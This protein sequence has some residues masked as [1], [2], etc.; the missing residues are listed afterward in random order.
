[1]S[2]LVIPRRMLGLI[3]KEMGGDS[4]PTGGGGS[5]LTITN[6]VDGY[7]LK[8]TGEANRVEGV[9]AIQYSTSGGPQLQISASTYISGA[10]N[11]LYMQG[12]NA[13]GDPARYQVHVSG[14]L[15]YVQE[16]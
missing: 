4:D 16:I 10:A 8:A 3:N 9:E 5:G 7:I 12:A 1:M 6:N 2:N 14:G 11:Y 13:A 15:L